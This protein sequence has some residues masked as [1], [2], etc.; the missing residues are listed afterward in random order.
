MRSDEI[1]RGVKRAPHRALLKALGVTDRDMDKPFIAVVNSFTTV[2]PGHIHLNR[3]AEEVKAGVRSAGGVPFEFNTIAVCDGIA[4]GHEGM[5][6]SLPS[7]EVI[8]D[9]VEIMVQAHRFDGMVLVT[10]CDKVTPGMLMAAARLNVPSIVVT[11]GP[12]LTGVLDGKRA[13]FASI[14]E[15]VGKVLAGEMSEGELKRLEDSACPGCGS[16]SGMFTANTMACITEAL[17]MS[18]PGCA[19][20]LAVSALK[21]RI[22][23]ESGER[24][25]EL[26]REDL[27]PS[28]I[29]T[30]KAFENAIAVDMALGGSTNAVLHLSAIAGEAG[31]SLPL[32]LFD[33]I[34]KR[35]PHLC[36]MIPSGPYALEDLDAAGGIPA[37]MKELSPLLHLGTVTV[38]GKT[39]EK[40]IEGAKVLN[41]EV[42][43]PLANPVH[44]EGG[45]AV[46]RGNL[47]PKGAVVKTAAVSPE[48][49]V[50][51][52]PARIFDSEEEAMKAIV[53]RK[54]ERG[55][56]VVIRYEGRK[57]GPGMREMLSPTATISGMG[58]SESVVLVTDGRFSGATRGP[59]VGHLSPEAADGG[60]IAALR[61]GD[62]IEINIPKRI[63]RVE[64]KDDEIKNRLRSWKPKPP[65]VKR[66]YLV[67]YSSLL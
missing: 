43:R 50:H 3:I 8:A 20:A 62:V 24:I 46:L 22:A 23:K 59:C 52:G 15:A 55:D 47:A 51:K 65:K 33:E 27:N 57:G 5:R 1:K 29:M 54:I 12:M 37:L 9:S 60:P 11:G 39:I 25:P 53:S 18:L 64:L 28:G 7:R 17:G 19:T 35:V 10:N 36:N 30:A 38:T 66:G 13:S 6:Y 31:T 34:S 40:N 21:L 4:M 58:L 45:I 14:S 42:I 49:L 67:R 26:L 41:A 63:L 48:M 61:N 2:V 16:C 32:S 44:K 56:V